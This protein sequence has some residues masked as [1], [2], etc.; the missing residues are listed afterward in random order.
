M[1]IT[2][3]VVSIIF[4]NASNGYT[5]LAVKTDK[6]ILTAVGETSEVQIDD[7]I[8]LEGVFD[9]HKAY[10]DQFKFSTFSK[11]M[12]QGRNALIQYISEN[13]KGIGKKIATNII[14]EFDSF[15]TQ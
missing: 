7:T 5:V 15:V 13:V 2:G 14:R 6:E 11:I 8:E 4:K 3:K 9:T 1:K 10:G 12:P